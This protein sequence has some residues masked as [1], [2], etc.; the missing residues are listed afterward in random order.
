MFGSGLERI[1]LHPVQ[2]QGLFVH[3]VP[4][5]LQTQTKMHT[6]TVC[7]GYHTR[8]D[9]LRAD[10]LC[11]SVS[12]SMCVKRKR[13]MSLPRRP[14]LSMRCN[15]PLCSSCLEGVAS[16]SLHGCWSRDKPCGHVQCIYSGS[17]WLD[18]WLTCGM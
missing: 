9:S 4:Y 8:L 16:L 7:L 10:L 15:S 6:C 1:H 2:K 11:G 14:R 17:G 18:W 5:Q 13:W 12:S 3:S